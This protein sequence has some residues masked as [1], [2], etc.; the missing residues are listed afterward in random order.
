MDFLIATTLTVGA[1]ILGTAV[2]APIMF[3]IDAT[4]FNGQLL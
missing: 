4:Y 1:V 3:W 2:L